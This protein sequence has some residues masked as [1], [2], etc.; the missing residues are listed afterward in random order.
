MKYL[1][2]DEYRNL[3]GTMDSSAFPV[4]ERKAEKI[5]D[6]Y[7]NN[8][9]KKATTIIPEVKE[10]MTDVINYIGQNDLVSDKVT[11]F[12]NGK[13]SFTYDTSQTNDNK[14]WNLAKM[15]LPFELINRGVS[16]EYKSE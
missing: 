4:L 10:Y 9:L 13:T 14:L 7:T 3:G 1:T 12:S 11:S 6:K 15:Y 16:H 2:L 5:T 8:R